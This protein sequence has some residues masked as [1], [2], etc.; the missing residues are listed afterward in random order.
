MKCTFEALGPPQWLQWRRS[1]GPVHW[2]MAA[3]TWQRER[4]SK[5]SYGDHVFLSL[6]L[7][8]SI[9][10]IIIISHMIGLIYKWDVG[11]YKRDVGQ[12]LVESKPSCWVIFFLSALFRDCH[13]TL[14]ESWV[15]PFSRHGSKQVVEREQR[16]QPS[17]CL[18]SSAMLH[19]VATVFWTKLKKCSVK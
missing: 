13:D 18:I 3:V 7:L 4:V 14:L 16:V 6:L 11:W 8:I 19:T 10:S 12:Y 2:P 17:R 1:A 15:W 9:N 5:A